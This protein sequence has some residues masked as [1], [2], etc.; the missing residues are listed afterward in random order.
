MKSA[1]KAALITVSVIAL[2]ALTG[3]SLYRLVVTSQIKDGGRMEN[4]D[5]YRV[6]KELVE[7]E[8]RQNHMNFY[9]SFSLKF[10]L[11]NDMPL[12]TGWFPSQSGGDEVRESG[13]DAFS[14]PVPWQLTW[15]QWL[16]LI[17][18]CSSSLVSSSS[19]RI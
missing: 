1:V 19:F 13:T 2:L 14:N 9:R 11:E 7:V 4:P 10:Y 18:I 12:L 16:S 3:C 17:H 6:G 15:V 5:A 8:W